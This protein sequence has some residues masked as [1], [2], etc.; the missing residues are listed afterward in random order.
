MKYE[1]VRARTFDSKNLQDHMSSNTLAALQDHMSSNALAAL[2]DHMSSNA[3][4]AQGL[5]FLHP[6]KY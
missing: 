6:G 2:Q 4:A 5:Y 1:S 3:L